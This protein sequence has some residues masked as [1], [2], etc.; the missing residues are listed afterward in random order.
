MRRGRF[1]LWDVFDDAAVGLED[2]LDMDDEIL[3]VG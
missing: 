2:I 1:L 3:Y